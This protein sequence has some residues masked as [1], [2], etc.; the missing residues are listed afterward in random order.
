MRRYF[1]SSTG[2]LHVSYLPL[3]LNNPNLLFPPSFTTTR[4]AFPLE[5]GSEEYPEILLYEEDPLNLAP[6]PP[7]LG[8][9]PV[10]STGNSSDTTLHEHM[11][12]YAGI[13][14]DMAR[15]EM[16]ASEKTWG[17][18]A[19]AV[20]VAYDPN[21][22]CIYTGNDLGVLRKFSLRQFMNSLEVNKKSKDPSSK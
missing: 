9:I 2:S 14:M 17:R 21:S 12:W 22:K 1:L 4:R 16:E 13:V 6:Q 5:S 15:N 7:A 3:L 8:E 19:P 20:T 18:I 10:G 11:E